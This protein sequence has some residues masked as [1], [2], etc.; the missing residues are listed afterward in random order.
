MSVNILPHSGDNNQTLQA[1]LEYLRRGWSVIPIHSIQSGRCTCGKLDCDSQGKHPRILDWTNQGTT[2]EKTIRQWWQRWPEAN[3]GILTGEKSGLLVLDVD[4]TE[5]AD[6]L[7]ELEA[8]HGPL[9]ETIE[10]ITGSGGRHVLFKYPVGR[11]IP[12]KARFQPGLDTRSNGGQFVAVPSLH[13]SGRRYAWDSEHHPDDITLADA[14]EWLLKLMETKPERHVAKPVAD[15]IPEGERN[16]TLT[17]LAGSMRR[18]GMSQEAI[19][20]AL[21][22]ENQAR[23]VPPLE[24]AEVDRI[25]GSVCQYAPAAEMQRGFNLEDKEEQTWPEDLA[26]EAFYG[27]AGEV[28]RA[29]S[30]YSEA[31][32]TALLINFL[33]AFGGVVGGEPY[34]MAGPDRHGINLFA[35][36]VGETSKGRKG[37]SWGWVRE[38]FKVIDLEWA[39]YKTPGGLSSGEG[40]IWQVRD[41][42]TQRQPVKDK[43]R[44]VD[45]EEIEIDP[46]ITDKRLLVIEAE[47]SSPLKMATR[48]GNT[49]SDIIRKAWDGGIL[50]AMTK[51]SPA[52]ATGA[53]ISII[54]HITRQELLKYL[55]DTEAANGFGNRF[56]WCCVQRSKYLPDGATMPQTEINGLATKINDAVI[57]A[58][59]AGEMTRDDGARDIWRAV[60]PSLSDGKQGL[61]GCMTARAE[62]QVLRLASLY[63]LLDQSNIVQRPHLLAALAVWERC[64][65]SAKYIFGD[66]TGDPLAET[67]LENL[68]GGPLTQTEISNLFSRKKSAE[69]IGRALRDLK[70]QSKVFEVQE[71][72][73][74]RSR[75]VWEL[76]R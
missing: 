42:I 31:D 38:L 29:I 9:P 45:Y 40:L 37:A 67:I 10:A 69:A 8:T 12:N 62:A 57:Y 13:L 7:A 33:V 35:V 48:V 4:G 58:R 64:E 20:A 56:L 71:Q 49:L 54:G 11:S 72:T 50:S 44:V 22:A 60:Y 25:A 19:G 16:A 68:Q 51:N 14:P 27:L 34:F 24:R 32:E 36:L 26:A 76:A 3:I 6:A 17:S 52:R 53:H 55:T 21:W 73:S 1:A 74:G 39:L 66:K 43:G 15:Y 46:G 70:A 59:Q 5:G 2:D 61:F 28:V 41:K 18:R 30:P 47:F 23:C 75:T 65:A 63:A